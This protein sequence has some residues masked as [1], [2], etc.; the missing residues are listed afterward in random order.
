M[1]K[2]LLLLTAL[3][4]M[5]CGALMAQEQ[6]TVAQKPKMRTVFFTFFGTGYTEFFNLRLGWQINDEWS[7]AAKLSF[8]DSEEDV[9]F[10][11]LFNAQITKYFPESEIIL[12]NISL[13]GGYYP[14]QG[15]EYAAVELYTGW[16]G[17]YRYVRPYWAIGFT[18]LSEKYSQ[19]KSN[20]FYPGFK[21]GFNFNL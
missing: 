10:T 2:K 13:S 17:V 19:S 11:A 12:N 7:V 8:Y 6:D 14:Y 1:T 3:V 20:H 21:V 5:L 4:L 18:F 9:L 15:D 16:E